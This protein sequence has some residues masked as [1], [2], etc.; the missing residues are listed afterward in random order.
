MG[1]EEYIPLASHF[2]IPIV[3]TGFEPVD[4]LS[5]ILKC[6]EMLENNRTGVENAYSRSVR[7][8]G[9]RA[10]QELLREVFVRSDRKWRG[11]GT[12]PGS[13]LE[14]ADGYREFDSMAKFKLQPA[15][16]ESAGP[17]IAG[18]ILTGRRKP[19]ECPAFGT[20]CKPESPLG[21]PM[22]ST[23]GACSAYYRYSRKTMGESKKV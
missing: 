20:L 22:V 4:I 19:S 1:T 8:E 17:C 7:P 14:L 12:I 3:V 5:G 23:E 6:I 13:G 2:Q 9:N 18:E 10:A 16:S 11:I 21:A 15:Q